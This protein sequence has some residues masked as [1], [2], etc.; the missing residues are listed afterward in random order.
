MGKKW[1]MRLGD[2]S[3]GAFGTT[4][5]DTTEVLLR[6]EILIYIQDHL[7]MS[8][9]L[10]LILCVFKNLAKKSCKR[11][12][13]LNELELC[14]RYIIKVIQFLH[15][16]LLQFNQTDSCHYQCHSCCYQ[17]LLRTGLYLVF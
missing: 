11:F 3:S 8:S 16:S 12:H 5:T 9:F 13:L 15:K 7:Q 4:L 2:K 6:I 17:I 1:E 10:N 14:R